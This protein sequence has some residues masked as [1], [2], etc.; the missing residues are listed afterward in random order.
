MKF[1]FTQPHSDCPY[2][3]SLIEFS[4]E[5]LPRPG[6]IRILA[7]LFPRSPELRLSHSLSLSIQRSDRIAPLFRPLCLCRVFVL[8]SNVGIILTAPSAPKLWFSCKSASNKSVDPRRDFPAS[9]Y[10]R[11]NLAITQLLDKSYGTRL[12]A[13]RGSISIIRSPKCP[14]KK[15]RVLFICSILFLLVIF[16]IK[17]SKLK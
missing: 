2:I 8:F 13:T 14:A 12:I 11:L 17:L 4:A 3:K 15:S 16:K 9:C 5:A 10:C 1:S 7:G 6:E